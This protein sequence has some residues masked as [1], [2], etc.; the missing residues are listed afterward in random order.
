M[1]K[2]SR[3]LSAPWVGAALLGA[4]VVSAGACGGIADEELFNSGATS[5][6]T[7]TGGAAT[8]STSST[9]STMVTSTGVGGDTTST[10]TSTGEGPGGA[11]GT[12]GGT[13]S[14]S[15][16][17]PT[18]GN[19]AKDMGEQC[20]MADFGNATCQNFGFSNP[21]G[22]VCTAG[23]KINLGGCKA[24]CDGQ[25]VEMGEVCDG[26]LLDGHD[27]TEVGFSTAAGVKCV[28]CQLDTSACKATCD[29]QKLETGEVCDGAQLNGHTCADLG[30]STPGGV[31]CTACQLDGAACKAT[32]GDGKLEPTE[33]CDDG[34]TMPGDGCDATC[35]TEVVASAGGTCGTAIPVSMG[36]GTQ[37]LSGSTVNGGNHTAQGCTSDAADRVYAIKVTANGFLTANLVRNQTSFDSVLYIGTSCSDA[38]AN[39]ALICNDSYDALSPVALTGGEVVSIRVQQNQLV[40]LV[41]DGYNAGDEGTYQLHLDLSAGTDCN[42]PV[43]IPLE[44]GTGMIVRG[45]NT[46]L[47]P[48]TQGSCGGAPGGQVVY[49]VTRAVTGPLDV[50]TVDAN[51]NYN[52]VL[53]ARSTCGNNNTELACSNNGGNAAELI[54]LASVNGGAVTY[55]Y[56]DGSTTGGGNPSGTFGLTFTP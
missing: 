50:D 21:A 38:N 10:S 4:G 31:K 11:G 56:V 20:D 13:S 51:T 6:A 7:G 22:L 42:D 18:C 25:K 52:S 37:N 40:Y 53:Y 27:C 34:N 39:T 35:H 26:A 24:T 46:N 16:G 9:A 5:G 36:L 47:F 48:T 32:C 49:A 14:T 29:G 12:G 33:Q 2:G 44:V 23:C 17:G 45:S 28:N 1:S 54:S 8:T 30:F 55:V 19:G 15:T 41:V 3:R 43:P